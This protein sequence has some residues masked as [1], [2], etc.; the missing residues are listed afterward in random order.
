MKAARF[1]TPLLAG[2]TV[3]LVA[4]NALPTMHRKHRLLEEKREL[5]RQLELERDRGRGLRERVRALKEDRFYVQRV[6]AE[7]WAGIPK[8]A[9]PFEPIKTCD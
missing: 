3:V 1:L 8:G 7:T 6:L 2:A 9:I 4:S 5:V